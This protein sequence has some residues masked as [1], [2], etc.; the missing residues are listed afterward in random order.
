MPLLAT[1]FFANLTNCFAILTFLFIIMKISH[2]EVNVIF[3]KHKTTTILPRW[4]N[5]RKIKI[6]APEAISYHF[7]HSHN[8]SCDSGDSV[9]FLDS[10]GFYLK[11]LIASTIA[12]INSM[13]FT[14]EPTF[15][16]FFIDMFLV[17]FIQFFNAV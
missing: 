4:K 11:L 5:K 16:A 8:F 3:Q 2:F 10:P 12:F 13:T 7:R 15:N 14:D 1:R 6:Q 9:R 17:L